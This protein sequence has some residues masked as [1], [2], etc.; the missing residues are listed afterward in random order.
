M[1]LILSLFINQRG[2]K[3]VHSISHRI[4]R[5]YFSK[6]GIVSFS[7]YVFTTVNCKFLFIYRELSWDYKQPFK[8]SDYF[9]ESRISFVKSES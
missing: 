4:D 1:Y 8:Y 2:A 3:V 9:D 6:Y 7:T 5:Y